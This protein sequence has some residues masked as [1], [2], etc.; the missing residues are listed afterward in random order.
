MAQD[1][2]SHLRAVLNEDEDFVGH[3]WST[4]AESPSNGD[5]NWTAIGAIV[6]GL[7]LD[8]LI[9]FGGVKLF[10]KLLR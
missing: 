7:T 6:V 8:T 3:G 10:R 5:I 4:H 1:R 9:V 2:Y